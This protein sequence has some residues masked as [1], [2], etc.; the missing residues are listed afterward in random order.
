MNRQYRRRQVVQ[1]ASAVSLGLLAACGRWPWQAQPAARGYRLGWLAFGSPSPSGTSPQY[2]ALQEGLR[3]LGYV[4]G[5]NLTVAA[6]YAEGRS[7][8]LPDLV[9]ELLSAQPDVIVAAGTPAARAAKTATSTIPIIIAYAADPVA[10]GLV[11]SL[12]HP[13]GNVTGLTNI[14]VELSGKRLQLLTEAVPG[15][16][17]V[18]AI[19][20]AADP[21]MLA[22]FGEARGG[23]ERLGLELQSI[24]VRELSDLERAYEAAMTWRA[25]A[26]LLIADPFIT[27]SRIP[28]VALS[29]QSRVPTMSGDRGFAAAGGL[30]AYGPDPLL[31]YRRAAYYID[32]IFKGAKP[33]DLPIERPMR[34]DFVINLKTAEALGLTIPP[35]VLLQATEVIQ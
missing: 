11:A 30:M 15:I 9:A 22:E 31:Q 29:A 7:E 21:A 16:A 3:D 14:A 2:D 35:H 33:A 6:R 24:A 17:R 32:R 23:A 12:A 25:D 18:A 26:I 8:G 4:A 13:G 34:F 27:L 19:W 28:L 10:T 1:G 5:H 20:N